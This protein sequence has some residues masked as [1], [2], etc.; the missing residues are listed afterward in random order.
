MY[1]DE[2]LHGAW[3]QRE[4]LSVLD[5]V[6][7]QVRKSLGADLLPL[8][9]AAVDSEE[10]IPVRLSDWDVLCRFADK[11]SIQ[12]L[13]AGI[14]RW[15][16]Q[17]N[18]TA[19]W[20]KAAALSTLQAW[21]YADGFR[22]DAVKMFPRE[23]PP[24][25]LP[26]YRQEE[27]NRREYLNRISQQAIE[28]IESHPVLKY[29]DPSHRVGFIESIMSNPIVRE[30]CER[31]ERLRSYAPKDRPHLLQHLTWVARYHVKGEKQV[32]IVREAEL[33]GTQLTASAV[34]QAVDSVLK[35]LQLRS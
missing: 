33:K 6:E 2:E 15:A 35:D 24:S 26:V 30:Y 22:L 16:M 21:N 3:L 9:Q 23:P 7:P 10:H 12:R 27:F 29:G 8:F 34:S 17:W 25:G 1:Y 31:A 14:N 11:P 20:C 5:E 32:A 19:E 18:L 13:H 4:F 28:A